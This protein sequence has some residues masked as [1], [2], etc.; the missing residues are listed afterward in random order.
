MRFFAVLIILLTTW[1][2]T[3]KGSTETSIDVSG[4]WLAQW[5][6]D[7]ASYPDVDPSTNF[8]MNGKFI[9]EEE[10]SLS[11]VAYGYPNC[12]F[13]SDTLSH[14]LNWQLKNDTLSLIN[15]NDVH[16]MTYQV[17]ELSEKKIKLQLMEDIF[18]HLTR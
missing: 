12:I 14:S 3:E 8:T 11:I 17:L 4:T 13:S 10:G 18:L 16:G 1:A 9:F 6:T 15:D 7:P 5:V 2:C